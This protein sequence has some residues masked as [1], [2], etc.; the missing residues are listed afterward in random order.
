MTNAEITVFMGLE[1]Q[2]SN[3]NFRDR[4]ALSML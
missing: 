2:L 3:F 1:L 4:E